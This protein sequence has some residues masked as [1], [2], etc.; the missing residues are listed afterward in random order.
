MQGRPSQQC[1][2]LSVSL[3]VPRNG[4]ERS[5]LMCGTARIKER[6]YGA[7]SSIPAR[8]ADGR[9]CDIAHCGVP[10]TTGVLATTT[11]TATLTERGGFR[12]PWIPL[13]PVSPASSHAQRRRSPQEKGKLIHGKYMHDHFSRDTQHP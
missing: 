9:R 7:I 6:R 11:T 13:S 8:K 5:D 2:R 1:H 12:L 4:L 3:L 10:L